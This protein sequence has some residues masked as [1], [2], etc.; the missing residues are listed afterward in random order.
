[1]KTTVILRHRLGGL[2][3]TAVCGCFDPIA[4]VATT[5]TGGSSSSTGGGPSTA[6]TGPDEA[7]GS[8][9]SSPST[10]IDPTGSTDPTDPDTTV[11]TGSSTTMG[12]EPACGDGSPDPG[13]ICLVEPP[14]TFVVGA[15]ARYVAAG[16]LGATVG[17]VTA[18]TDSFTI[19]ILTGDGIGGFAAPVSKSVGN[20]D[21]GGPIA[22]GVG[23][24]EPDG[25]VDIVARAPQETRWWLN[26]GAGQFPG[27]GD[28]VATNSIFPS[29]SLVIDNFDGNAALDV[30]HSDGYNI[31]FLLGS[32]DFNGM[33]GMGDGSGC[34]SS[35]QVFEDGFVAA[36]E[37]GF[38]GDGFRDLVVAASWGPMLTAV[39][40]NGNGT[41]MTMGAAGNG[42]DVCA[43]AN[44]SLNTIGA[45]DLD[46]DG[47]IELLAAHD[48]GI[49]IAPGNGDGSFGMPYAMPVDDAHA[50]VTVDLDGDGTL[51]I[52]VAARMAQALLVF[53]GMGDGSFAEPLVFAVGEDVVSVAVDDLDDDGALDLVTT[54]G[55]AGSGTVAVFLSD[56]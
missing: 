13:E 28:A 36:T 11:D 49:S 17:V 35:I 43:P 54:Y 14:A 53:R 5:E 34:S 32:V 40:G 12:P 8:P 1:M 44:C 7:S 50:L 29:V 37:Y 27:N 19:T 26:N 15:G 31:C 22:V 4:P 42:L 51:D 18:N 45:A 3:C 48:Q 38:D 10:T 41:F 6:P 21:D 25:D 46:G 23:D 47:E 33:Y 2:L 55:D 30:A 24:L 20:S 52:V 9:T 56:P 39:R 16:L